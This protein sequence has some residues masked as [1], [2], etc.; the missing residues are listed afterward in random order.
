MISIGD[1]SVRYETVDDG[2]QRVLEVG[3]RVVVTS[4]ADR[5]F[6]REHGMG[7]IWAH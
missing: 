1:H 2:E 4:I 5:I 6:W 7:C 3:S